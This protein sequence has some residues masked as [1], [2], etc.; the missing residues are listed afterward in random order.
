[1]PLEADGKLPA[2]AGSFAQRLFGQARRQ[3]SEHQ[4]DSCP[5]MF[6]VIPTARGKGKDDQM[7]QSCCPVSHTLSSRYQG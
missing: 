5:R 3:E 2:S 6:G 7:A 4:R 1:M